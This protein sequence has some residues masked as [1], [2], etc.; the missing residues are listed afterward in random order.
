MRGRT[1]TEGQPCA[2]PVVEREWR[3]SGQR[4]GRPDQRAG[5]HGWAARTRSEERRVGEGGGGG[6]G[7]DQWKK[8][9]WTQQRGVE[10]QWRGLYGQPVAVGGRLTGEWEG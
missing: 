8:K 3:E 6:G 9:R 2:L 5:G 1:V 7:G 10:S 4:A